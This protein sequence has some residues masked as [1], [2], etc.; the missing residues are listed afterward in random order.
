MKNLFM[1]LL[2][3]LL[4]TLP[5]GAQSAET[6]AAGDIKN[7]AGTVHVQRAG[8]SLVPV[9]GDKVQA[10]D[11]IR[12]GSDGSIGISFVDG[13]RVSLGPSSEFSVQEYLFA[14]LEG[15][16][17]FAAKLFKGT[18]AYTSGKIGKLSPSSVKI[19]TPQATIGIRGTSFVLKVD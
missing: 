16:F 18:A 6:E 10:M 19:T 14:P 12:T 5:C 7:I 1:V 4:L 9:V 8:A 15:D 3:A 11:S 13:T 2:V 17:S